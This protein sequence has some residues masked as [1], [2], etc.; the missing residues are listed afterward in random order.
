MTTSAT[1]NQLGSPNN[2]PHDHN[3]P[4]LFRIEVNGHEIEF[5]NPTPH[6]REILLTA[7]LKPSDEHVLI[8][9]L[10]HGTEM[11]GLDQE[12][13][14]RGP[15][16]KA[17]RAFLSDRVFLFTVDGHGYQWGTS[18][19]TEPGLRAVAD[20][21]SGSVLVLERPIGEEDVLADNDAVRLADGGTEHLRTETRL[22]RVFLDDVIEKLITRGKHTTKDLLTLLGVAAGYLLNVLDHGQLNPLQP[23]QTVYVKEGMKFYSQAPAGGS[24]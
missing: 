21:P 22:V 11:I 8:E 3:S 17:F 6:G 19:I 13:D 14:L 10:H 15:D 16:R 2:H 5:A 12:V 4:G 23:G 7:G 24:S 20:V 9:L 1:A 18:V